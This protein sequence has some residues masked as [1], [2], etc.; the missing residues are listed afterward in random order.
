VWVGVCLPGAG[1]GHRG[2]R[3]CSAGGM[4]VRRRR[5]ALR[6]GDHTAAAANAGTVCT[7]L[8]VPHFVRRNV[9][10]L[11]SGISVYTYIG[12]HGSDELRVPY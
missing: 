4:R 8:L 9:T 7:K 12:A 5:C 3:C 10:K 6:S 11:T 2:A 1:D